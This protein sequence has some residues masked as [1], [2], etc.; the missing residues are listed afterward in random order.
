LSLRI[1]LRCR[2]S[3]FLTFG[4]ESCKLDTSRFLTGGLLSLRVQLRCRLSR[5]FLAFG[6]ES[7]K[8][9]TSRFLT[10]GLLSLRIQLRCRLSRSFLAFGPRVVQARDEPLP[11]GRPPVARVLRHTV[12]IS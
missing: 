1:Q 9:E 6:L 12:G 3:R 11:D 10:G 5:S 4:L 2:L 8:L 7:C